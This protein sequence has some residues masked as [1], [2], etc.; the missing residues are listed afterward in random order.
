MER[1]KHD[2]RSLRQRPPSIRRV[3][4]LDRRLGGGE[5]PRRPI[6]PFATTRRIGMQE[7]AYRAAE[8]RLWNVVGARPTE[9]RL[10]LRRTGVTVRVQEVGSGPAVL[11]VHGVNTSGIS[12]LGHDLVARDRVAPQPRTLASRVV[13][14]HPRRRGR[15]R[16]RTHSDRRFDAALCT[17]WLQD[18][19]DD[20]LELGLGH[21]PAPT[22]HR[23][24]HRAWRPRPE[25][26]EDGGV[27]R[28]ASRPPS[29]SGTCAIWRRRGGRPKV[30][31]VAGCW[32]KRSSS[33]SRRAVSRS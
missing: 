13:H 1:R 28:M 11:F 10:G 16:L 5:A 3:R 6:S 17:G 4:L 24:R 14:P 29:R 27:I 20:D 22:A 9:R 32:P 25:V 23:K 18:P 33:A 31:G 12:W 7:A 15:R 2:R 30:D 26:D 8:G 21:Q 19:P